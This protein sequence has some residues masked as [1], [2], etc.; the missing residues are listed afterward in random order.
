[1]GRAQQGSAMKQIRPITAQDRQEILDLLVSTEAFQPHELAVAMELVDVAL[2][3]PGQEDY[4]P[5]VLEDDGT[6][7]AYACFG[8]N[9]MTRSTYDLYW[10]ATR[11]DRM[12]QGHGQAL[13]RFVEEEIK[14]RGGRLLVI[15][16]SSKESYGG[17]REFYTRVGCELAGRLPDF[18]D[19]GD[20]RVIYIKRL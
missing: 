14:R 19:V 16:T 13:L 15:E 12:R 2:H 11:R 9:P 4:Y 10:L 7:A 17:S 3:K 20:D 1:V 18:Y 5:Y 8:R 6:L